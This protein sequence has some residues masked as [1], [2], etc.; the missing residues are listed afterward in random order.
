MIKRPD[1]NLFVLTELPHG[2]PAAALTLHNLPPC[3]GLVRPHRL[4]CEA[5]VLTECFAHPQDQLGER[6]SL[7]GDGRR[8]G[9]ARINLTGI[10]AAGID[11]IH[12]RKGR[13]L[14]LVY[15]I[16]EGGLRPND[17]SPGACL[18]V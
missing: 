6:V 8:R 10:T 4:L 13:F 15:P 11:E 17:P 18:P 3:W 1:R 5:A 12:W 14:I 9:R 2:Q 7:G 16:N